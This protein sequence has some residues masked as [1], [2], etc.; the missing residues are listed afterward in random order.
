MN[1]HP[2]WFVGFDLGPSG[3][4][5]TLAVLERS[6][7]Q[8][9]APAPMPEQDYALRHL[10]RFAPGTPYATIIAAVRALLATPALQRSIL[11]VDQTGVGRLVKEAL[12]A[13]LRGQ[14]EALHA[15]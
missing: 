11:G 8:T 15:Q 14:V 13:G 3:Q 5:T 2:R 7:V 1:T 6:L 12:L 10:Q 9:H 4:F